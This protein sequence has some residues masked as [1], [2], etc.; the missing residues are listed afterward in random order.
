M[1]A[2][3][4]RRL[5]QKGG[6]SMRLALGI[7]MLAVVIA[8]GVPATAH[9]SN[10]HYFDMAKVVTLDGVVLRVRCINPHVILYLQS[11]NATGEQETWVIHGAS[12]SNAVRQVGLK[13][14]LQ[15]GISVTVRA[16]PSR[17]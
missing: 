4:L 16:W 2:P 5:M 15:P 17:V 6:G 1:D 8:S 13:D 10:P 3:D 7:A 11:K 12:L 9:H 14:R